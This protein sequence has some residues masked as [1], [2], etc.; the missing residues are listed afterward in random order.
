MANELFILV[1]D[2]DCVMIDRDATAERAKRIVAE[3][4]DDVILGCTESENK[5]MAREYLDFVN[6]GFAS[7]DSYPLTAVVTVVLHLIGA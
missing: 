4:P 6:D 2:T 3:N 5:K 7:I 1:D